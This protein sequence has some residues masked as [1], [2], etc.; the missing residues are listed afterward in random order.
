MS[1][2]FLTKLIVKTFTTSAF[3]CGTIPISFLIGKL[4]MS[5]RA[6]VS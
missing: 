3:I 6:R 4:D 5:S 1:L 2:N